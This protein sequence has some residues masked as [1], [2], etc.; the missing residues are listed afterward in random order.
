[1]GSRLGLSGARLIALSMFAYILKNLMLLHKQ[2]FSRGDDTPLPRDLGAE[3]QTPQGRLAIPQDAETQT[4]A[5]G[6]ANMEVLGSA[7]WLPSE[8]WVQG[9]PSEL[10]QLLR[11]YPEGEHGRRATPQSPVLTHQRSH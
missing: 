8:L 10:G 5:S 2:R 1:M 7:P 11:S 4:A 9:C 3:A 6:E